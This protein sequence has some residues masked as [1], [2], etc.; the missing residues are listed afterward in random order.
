MAGLFRKI[1]WIYPSSLLDI[2]QHLILDARI[3]WTNKYRQ[4]DICW[5]EKDIFQIESKVEECTISKRVAGGLKP[6]DI[7]PSE[8]HTKVTVDV[9]VMSEKIA[10]DKLK[11][12]K[13][14][15]SDSIILDIDEDF[16]GTEYA[17]QNL[18][19]SGVNP[20]LLE[21][22]QDNLADLFCPKDI[23]SCESI[24]RMLVLAIE[25][26]QDPKSCRWTYSECSNEKRISEATHIIRHGLHAWINSTCKDSLVESGE[27]IDSL[28][29]GLAELKENQLKAIKALGFCWNTTPRGFQ[30]LHPTMFG[31]CTGLNLPGDDIVAV[32]IH[33]TNLTDI[34]LRTSNLEKILSTLRKHPPSLITVCRSVRDGYTPRHFWKKIERDILDVLKYSFV[35]L[36]IHYDRD[37]QGG[38]PGWRYEDDSN[39]MPY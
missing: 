16:Y 27:Y 14:Q 30:E 22:F 21:T 15:Q 31:I 19:D 13:W 6:H 10:Y 39:F 2:P 24:D 7:L 36:N 9:E 26:L 20:E 33:K 28:V 38:R 34:E 12:G 17:S 29:S 23:T 8:C 3:G 4:F 37:L 35:D 11:S 25:H 1:I 18:H 32:Q 5:C